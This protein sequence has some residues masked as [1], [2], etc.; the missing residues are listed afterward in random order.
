MPEENGEKA[1]VVLMTVL[2]CAQGMANVLETYSA[3]E[4]EKTPEKRIPM[5]LVLLDF[6]TEPAGGYVSYGKKRHTRARTATEYVRKA[7]ARTKD[8]MIDLVIASHADMDHWALLPPLITDL[9]KDYPTQK[10]EEQKFIKR[11]IKGGL[12]KHWN[13]KEKRDFISELNKVIKYTGEFENLSKY[14][15]DV[16]DLETGYSNY[17]SV[18][19]KDFEKIPSLLG[20]DGVKFRSL[21]T[22]LPSGDDPINTAS[23]VL[24]VDFEGQ[25]LVLPGDATW[26]TLNE[27]NSILSGW[28]QSPVMPVILMTVPHHGSRSSAVEMLDPPP[29]IEQEDGTEERPKKRKK[30][31]IEKVPNFGHLEKF[32][33]LTKPGAVVASAYY[34]KTGYHPHGSILGRMGKYTYHN[35]LQVNG[36]LKDLIGAH[37]VVF[38]HQM[39]LNEH[40]QQYQVPK[41]P[42][43]NIFTTRLSIEKS[44]KVKVGN[45][46]VACN[47]S[48]YLYVMRKDGTTQH[49]RPNTAEAF[50]ALKACAPVDPPWSLPTEAKDAAMTPLVKTEEEPENTDM[51]LDLLPTPPQ[52]VPTIL[53]ANPAFYQ[54]YRQT[55]R[56]PF[57]SREGHPYRTLNPIAAASR[58]VGGRAPFCVL[59]VHRVRPLRPSADSVTEA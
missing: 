35:E 19:D 45:S 53:S 2:W 22:N 18:L 46:E 16:T 26:R 39:S 24:T 30:K 52:E 21:I 25:R 56:H 58:P 57:P 34:G 37:P 11:F 9:K 43:Q 36:L 59:P 40:W 49:W 29:A 3:I 27:A 32:V 14:F 41:K 42:G 33:A 12:P 54:R 7:V 50:S 15:H 20:I 44:T 47:V 10:G 51:V 13:P 55:G 28:G 48:D 1:H 31:E 8:H 23:L 4:W 5:S 6:G 38:T 17:R